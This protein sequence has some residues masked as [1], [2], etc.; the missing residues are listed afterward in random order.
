MTHIV[1][2]LDFYEFLFRTL[3]GVCVRMELAS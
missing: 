3:V 2:F 1:R